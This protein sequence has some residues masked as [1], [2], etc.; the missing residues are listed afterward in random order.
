MKR[1]T[2]KK[3]FFGD[4]LTKI[5]MKSFLKI[6]CSELTLNCTKL[7]HATNWREKLGCFCLKGC[8]EQLCMCM[9]E[10]RNGVLKMINKSSKTKK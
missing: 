9:Y 10:N 2:F 6:C 8:N 1:N 3:Y 7:T 5:P 4:F